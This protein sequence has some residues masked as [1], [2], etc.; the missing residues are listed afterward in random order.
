MYTVTI[1]PLTKRRNAKELT[2]FSGL[3]FPVGSVVTVPLGTREQ[4]GVVIETEPV[5]ATKAQ[6]RSSSFELRKLPRQAP[7]AVIPATLVRALAETAREYAT[8][9]SPLLCQFV[10]N[11]LRKQDDVTLL[12][13]APPTPSLRGFVVPRIYQGLAEHRIEFYRSAIREGFASRGSTLVVCP[14]VAEAEHLYSVLCEGIEPYTFLLHGTRT[15]K[16]L[17]ETL[18]SIAAQKHPVVVVCTARFMGVPRA[19]ATTIIVER[20]SAPQHRLQVHPHIDVRHVA[21][22]YAG[23]LGGQLF[24]ADLP[25]S[26]ESIHRKQLGDYEEVVSGH[27]RLRFKSGVDVVSMVGEARKPKEPFH[28]IG[29]D[30]LTRVH[31]VLERQGRVLLYV[32]RRGLAPTTVCAD[33]GTTV[34]CRECGATVVLHR[35]REENHFLCH[36]CGA[37]R[38]ARERCV[39]CNSWRLE[40]LGIGADLVFEELQRRLPQATTLRITKDATTT[41]RQVQQVVDQFYAESGTVLVTTELA[42]PYL[43]KHIPLVGIVSLDTLLTVPQWSIYERIASTL[44]RCRE[45]AG[46]TL[47][48]QTRHPDTKLFS[49]VLSGNFSTYYRAELRA[50][51]QLGYPPFSLLIKITA[52]GKQRQVDDAMQALSSALAPTSVVVYPHTF[53]HGRGMVRGIAYTRMQHDDPTLPSLKEKL[54]DLPPIYSVEMYPNSI[55]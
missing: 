54:R 28:A 26:I 14:T 30:L 5:R 43:H 52:V 1:A 37:D 29:R 49:Q 12:P 33:C 16:V 17:H 47:L 53:G 19:D 35:G 15:P 44:T 25:L 42:L 45:L 13:L 2:Y 27:H 4:L 20:E 38:H 9:I 8:T 22:H 3:A 46:E 6:L 34:T 39:H 7:C 11:A 51:E 55:L 23:V 36:A 32:T 50:R 21:Y 40:M 31:A 24:L 18:A 41:H 48:I 10:P